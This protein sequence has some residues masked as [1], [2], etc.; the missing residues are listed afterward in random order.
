[1]IV[2]G[3]KRGYGP[4]SVIHDLDLRIERGEFVVLLG[5]RGSG[6]TRSPI[7]PWCAGA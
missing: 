7:E 1:V 4:R 2:Q 6:K 3:P 5:E